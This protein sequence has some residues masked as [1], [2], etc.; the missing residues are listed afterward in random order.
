MAEFVR[1]GGDDEAFS[2]E[3]VEADI[4]SP[5]RHATGLA[6][7]DDGDT[8]PIK[9]L[10]VFI[11]YEAPKKLVGDMRSNALE[12]NKVMCSGQLKELLESKGISTEVALTASLKYHASV[13]DS[14]VSKVVDHR[15]FKIGSLGLLWF[16][17]LLDDPSAVVPDTDIEVVLV[18]SESDLSSLTPSCP[19][20]RYA[21]VLSTT[22]QRYGPWRLISLSSG[23]STAMTRLKQLIYVQEAVIYEAAKL[24]PDSTALSTVLSPSEVEEYGSVTQAEWQ[25]YIR[26]P[27]L[28][29]EAGAVLKKVVESSQIMHMAV[30]K[31]VEGG[32]QTNNGEKVLKF[33]EFTEELGAKIEVELKTGGSE[34]EGELRKLGNVM[35]FQTVVACLKFPGATSVAI[36]RLRRVLHLLIS[37]IFRESD[38]WKGCFR[39]TH[40]K[41]VTEGSSVC[42]LLTCNL[43]SIISFCKAAG[44]RKFRHLLTLLTSLWVLPQGQSV[45][46]VSFEMME[47]VGEFLSGKSPKALKTVQNIAWTDLWRGIN[48][49]ETYMQGC[50][51]EGTSEEEVDLEGAKKEAEKWLG[52][53]NFAGKEGSTKSR[54]MARH[55][56]EQLSSVSPLDDVSFEAYGPGFSVTG[57]SHIAG[58]QALYELL[59]L[60]PKK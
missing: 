30:A 44:G 14:F 58:L 54:E 38:S 13:C 23:L 7:R 53:L 50:W 16:H 26:N 40:L 46:K 43:A 37:L 49:K 42:V 33:G 20:H 4:L 10:T 22:A 36:P 8:K 56:F 27:A 15:I 32:E 57:Q 21:F 9:P 41:Y 55:I 29:K 17:M 25:T 24:A 51:V 45:Y 5:Q 48:K 31:A 3:E 47:R 12:I 2:E 6:G 35:P 52:W 39:L 18:R 59:R 34:R 60:A 11:P 1:P 19:I 28:G